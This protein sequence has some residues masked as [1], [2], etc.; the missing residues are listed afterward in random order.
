MN[1]Q[2]DPLMEL[3]NLAPLESMPAEVYSFESCT[4]VVDAVASLESVY[5]TLED[6]RH[7]QQ[8]PTGLTIAMMSHIVTDCQPYVINEAQYSF[9]SD[10]YFERNDVVAS[11]EGIGRVI[12]NTIK[13]IIRRIM[14]MIRSVSTYFRNTFNRVK[15][16]KN[17]GV[18]LVKRIRATK[19]QPSSV[20]YPH[21][22]VSHLLSDGEML[23]GQA[24]VTGCRSR[25]QS[26]ST[27]MRTLSTNRG[28]ELSEKTASYLKHSRDLVDTM[29]S[30]RHDI[31]NY[32]TRTLSGFSDNLFNLV[33]EDSRPKLQRQEATHYVL[34]AH[35]QSHQA[36]LPLAES[37]VNVLDQVIQYNANWSKRERFTTELTRIIE[38][39]YKAQRPAQVVLEGSVTDGIAR[40]QEMRTSFLLI[41]E[42]YLACEL[43][44]VETATEAARE[45]M[46]LTKKLCDIHKA[47]L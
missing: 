2:K 21:L 31:E 32:I 3:D 46:V 39:G 17:M 26:F 30:Y 19:L 10:N 35:P 29:S 12:V 37:C 7:K 6:M 15:Q 1:Q 8:A 43:A 11:M 34:G 24:T 40:A 28:F 33:F 23:S 41:W 13:E 36:I 18:E 4:N 14:Q 25:L 20:P 27:A 9:E 16:M 42:S 22:Q 47:Y 5:D 44:M 38:D 45:G